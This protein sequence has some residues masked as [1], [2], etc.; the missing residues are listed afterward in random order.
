MQ[1]RSRVRWKQERPP[2][3]TGADLNIYE[4]LKYV[5]GIQTEERVRELVQGICRRLNTTMTV[6]YKN[7][8]S[9]RIIECNCENRR[10]GKPVVIL[11]PLL[12]GGKSWGEYVFAMPSST[13]YLGG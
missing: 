11:S 6:K 2:T 10:I 8:A 3:A 13:V 4:L 9:H 1:F 12:P 5:S 7:K